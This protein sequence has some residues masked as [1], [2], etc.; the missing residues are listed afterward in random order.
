MERN[1][2]TPRG[3]LGQAALRREN[4]DIFPQSKN[5]GA[6]RNVHCQGTAREQHVTL[7]FPCGPCQAPTATGMHAT[8]E[9]VLEAVFSMR[10]VPKLHKESVL[11]YEL[12]E[13]RI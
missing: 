8:T 7:C 5:C 12:V 3:Y 6:R 11:S 2:D 9:E 4:C 13:L 1:G 10:S